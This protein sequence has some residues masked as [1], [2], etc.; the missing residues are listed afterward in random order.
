MPITQR[1]RIRRVCLPTGLVENKLQPPT[2]AAD[3]CTGKGWDRM[4]EVGGSWGQEC[5]CGVPVMGSLSHACLEP[6]LRE[7]VWGSIKT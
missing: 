1:Q 2:T 5:L 7:N 3:I 6:L 4:W